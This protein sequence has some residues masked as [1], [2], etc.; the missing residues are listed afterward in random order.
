MDAF[1]IS[2]W[3]NGALRCEAAQRED[4]QHCCQERSSYLVA[5]FSLDRP[6]PMLGS[7]ALPPLTPILVH[8]LLRYLIS[9]E[10]NTEAFNAL[11]RLRSKDA[12]GPRLSG[13]ENA[14]LLKL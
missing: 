9:R 5:S 10:K 2:L 11:L 13:M 6:G 1:D 8:A 7:D 3:H 14:M 12:S 4:L